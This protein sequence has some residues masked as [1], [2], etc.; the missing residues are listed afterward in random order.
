MKDFL[1]IL[2]KWL[3]WLAFVAILALPNLF[4]LGIALA[5]AVFTQ[6][7]LNKWLPA[8]ISW[9]G[10][11]AVIL[12][13]LYQIYRGF[14]PSAEFSIS[15]YKTITGDSLAHDIKVVYGS[16][17]YPTFHPDY[18]STALLLFTNNK[19]E[20]QLKVLEEDTSF[21]DSIIMRSDSY[22]DVVRYLKNGPDYLHKFSKRDSRNFLFIGFISE[23]RALINR[24]YD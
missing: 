8:A 22:D 17:T 14:Y 20:R 6:R 19:Y 1:A 7:V 23:S 13:V 12:T 21:K 18:C 10:F 4:L 9:I 3:E 15:E 11:A 5:G 2:G 16:A 24:C